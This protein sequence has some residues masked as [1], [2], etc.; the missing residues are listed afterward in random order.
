MDFFR[1]IAE[2]VAK[3]LDWGTKSVQT[4][5][6]VF[7][8]TAEY[9]GTRAIDG[10]MYAGAK[11][12]DGAI[13]VGTKAVDGAIYVGARTVDAAQYVGGKAV[14][15]ASYVGTQA[16]DGA[17]YAGGKAVDGAHYVGN[18]TFEK[19]RGALDNRDSYCLRQDVIQQCPSAVSAHPNPNDG[20]FMGADC[21]MGEGPP[22]QGVLPAGCSPGCG[23]PKIYFTNGIGNEEND[24]CATMHALAESQCAEVVGIYNATYGDK[25]KLEGKGV[26]LLNDVADCM[27]AIDESGRSQAATNLK[28]LLV[29]ELREGK[30]I[31]VYAHSEGGLNTQ[32]ALREAR[33]E[34]ASEARGRLL[35][36]GADFEQAS[37]MS[38]SA[39]TRLM[40]NVNVTSFGT[41]ENGWV[42]GPNYTQYENYLDPV[43]KAIKLAQA[44]R[45]KGTT[46]TN[47]IRHTAMQGLGGGGL[48]G[49]GMVGIYVPMLN[50]QQP[51]T[52]G[53]NGKCC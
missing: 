8:T 51:A 34:L 9:V 47:A 11:T 17:K 25:A 26:G 33:K 48:P 44:A 20:N 5:A 12:V 52:R 21:Q 1:T 40:G 18:K 49:H 37:A 31:T 3:G 42:G 13:Y 6:R 46:P 15:G 36:N 16:A 14:D 10:V 45:Q 32:T 23:K 2:N 50:D 43:P 28:D 7:G 27:D 30:N 39:A 38:A 29:K 24:L 35:V 4:S 19:V 41:A 53:A 22:D